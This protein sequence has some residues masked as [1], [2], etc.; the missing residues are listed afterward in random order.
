MICGCA[1]P[2]QVKITQNGSPKY[3]KVDIQYQ[4]HS[5]RD[6]FKPPEAD[7][8]ELVDYKT[9]GKNEKDPTQWTKSNLLIQYPHPEGKK[10][11]ALATL[12][13]TQ[14]SF[15]SLHEELNEEFQQGLKRSKDNDSSKTKSHNSHSSKGNSS[16]SIKEEIWK[17]ELPKEQLDLLILELSK[18]GFFDN[19]SRPIGETYLSI[20]IDKGNLAKKW[21][22]EPRLE[23]FI[24]R[25][26]E[27]GSLDSFNTEASPKEPS[28]L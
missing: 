22:Q 28:Q 7:Q 24:K 12:S 18:S 8:V 17:W 11:I 6:A 14:A 26:Y 9:D 1:I 23:D 15:N 27:N 21:T 3:D 19:Q 2:Y 4:T 5:S 16:T 25:I 10:G 13:M 20:Q